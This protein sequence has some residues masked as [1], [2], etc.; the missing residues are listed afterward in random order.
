MLIV[1]PIAFEKPKIT[2]FPLTLNRND[3]P[4]KTLKFS[5]TIQSSIDKQ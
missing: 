4:P 5:K 1:G 3:S 2:A